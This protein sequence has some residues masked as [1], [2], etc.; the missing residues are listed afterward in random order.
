MKKNI[1]FL[2]QR[3]VIRYQEIVINKNLFKNNRKDNTRL[4]HNNCLVSGL[5]HQRK[6]QV[7]KKHELF[8][9]YC[10]IFLYMI[11]KYEFLD[12]FNSANSFN[13]NLL[14]IFLEGA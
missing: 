11:I 2:K 4:N 5:F 9:F 7:R 13:N 3:N 6:K 14:H 8:N 10:N 12:F 1:L